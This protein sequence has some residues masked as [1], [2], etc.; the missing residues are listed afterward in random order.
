[1]T[2]VLRISMVDRRG[3]VLF[4]NSNYT[5]RE[6]YQVAREVTSFFDE[7]TPALQRMSRD[8]AKTLVSD[9]LEGF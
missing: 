1:V 3:H 5:F 6:Q 4:E 8:F 9:I 7:E 2:V